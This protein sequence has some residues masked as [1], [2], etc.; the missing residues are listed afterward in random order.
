[1]THRVPRWAVAP[2]LALA[3]LGSGC[4]LLPAALRSGGD[5][6]P[7]AAAAPAGA[8][9]A[10]PGVEVRVVAPQPLRDLLA[11]HLD[12][13]RLG[14]LPRDEVDEQEWSRLVDATP[15]QARELLETEGYFQSQVTLSRQR[16]GAAGDPDEVT[17][18]VDPGPRALVGRVTLQAEGELERGA[19][20]GEAHASA[21]LEA[22]RRQW[23]LPSGTPFRNASWSAAKNTALSRLRAAGYATAVWAGTGAEVDVESGRVRLFLVADSGPLFRLGQLQIEGLVRHDADTVRDLLGATAG[24]PLTETL[25]LDFQE[26]LQK[27]GLFDGVTV[28][29]DPDPAQAAAATLVARLR[30]APLQVYTAGVGYSANNGPRA[31]LEHTYRRVFGYAVSS[32]NKLEWAQR[33]QLWDGELSTHPGEGL[34]RN[35]LGVAI[36]RQES[37]SDTVLSQRLRL[38][39]AQEG[40]RIERLY[41]AE[42]ERSRQRKPG[43]DPVDANAYS[44]N[45]HGVWRGLDSILLPTEG[46]SFSGQ[47]GLGRADGTDARPGPFTRAYGRL[48][49]YR[50]IGASFY[51][52]ARLEIGQV[53]LRTGMVLPESQRFRVGG[54]DSVR[55]YGYRSLGPQVAGVT[56]SGTVMATASVEIARP[57]SAAL[58]SVWWAV[59]ADAG[60][61]ANNFKHLDP[62]LGVG[63]GVRWRSPVGPLKL[64]Y[65]WGRETRK[66]RLHFSVGIAF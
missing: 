56:D 41:Y 53:F 52:Q 15:A 44:V 5:A 1:M 65:A 36:E 27:S 20:A 6:P 3:L 48:T 32:R 64:D 34:W 55:G 29:L 4:A 45:Y 26:R 24:T 42:A 60:N 57:V 11:Q 21:T 7:A 23:E 40:Q 43:S 58:P 10:P 31:S 33:R 19:G 9:S 17:V 35:L 50:P 13:A 16:G 30:E 59:F 22:L 61:A 46:Y 39:R 28:T 49:V 38:G 62:V 47:L 63:A 66:F 18:R 14:R 8:A 51:G 37:S 25:L 12:L 54:D 2:L